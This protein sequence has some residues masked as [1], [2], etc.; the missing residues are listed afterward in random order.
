MTQN[1]FKVYGYR[2]VVLL[3]FMTVIA[4][5]Q[6]LWITFAAITT[7]AMQFY[8]V[9]ELSIGLLSLSFMIVYIIISFPASWAIDTYGIRAGVGIGAALTGIFGLTRGLV[10]SSYTWVLVAQIGIAIGQ[11]FIL[12]AVT[13][14]AARWFPMQ[15]RATASGLGSLAIYLGILVGL[16][17]TPYLTLQSGIP[18]MLITYGI[19]SAVA[20]FVFFLFARERPPSPP[21]PPDQEGR[22]LVLDGLTRMI[23]QRDFIL[24]LIIFF[25]GLGA[26]N[27]ITT[28]IDQ[29]LVPHGFSATQTGNA[30][31]MMI[32][33][34]ILGAVILPLLSDRYRK[35]APFLVLAVIGATIGLA[36]ITY[37]TNYGLLLVFSFIFGFFLLSAGPI[38]FQYGAEITY[39]A[40]EGTSNGLLLLMGQISGIIFILG[41]DAF[42]SPQTGS[43]TMP[44]I[45]LIG[46]MVICLFLGTRLREAQR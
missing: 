24:L 33:G 37:V 9:S 28:W 2:W 18:G 17:F 5:N 14:V 35:R 7:Q 19:V 29:I 30:G 21:C 22:S 45:V 31:G 32:F 42:K 34:G 10:A 36:G 15:E 39:P 23:R 44:L 6:L 13:T 20:M 12:N 3:T 26:F 11:P 38:G 46:L 1:S 8:N 43:M 4:L 41:M 16:A 40:P 25:V 27:A